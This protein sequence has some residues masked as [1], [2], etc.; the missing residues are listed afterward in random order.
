MFVFIHMVSILILSY[1][2]CV[3]VIFEHFRS[4][5]FKCVYIHLSPYV[6]RAI[7]M[8]LTTCRPNGTKLYWPAV[9]CYCEA[10]IRL[11]VASPGLCG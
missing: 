10:I 2:V 6:V 3:F 8:H 1:I 4:Y 9:E 11:E 7:D 5:V